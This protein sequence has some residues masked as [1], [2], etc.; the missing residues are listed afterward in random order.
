[1]K[2]LVLL[3]QSCWCPAVQMRHHLPWHCCICCFCDSCEGDAQWL[4]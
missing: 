2:L 3:G 4:G 1:M